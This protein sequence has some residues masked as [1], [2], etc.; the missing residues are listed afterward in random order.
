MRAMVT[1]AAGF[2]GSHICE[3]LI[4]EGN[5]VVGVDNLSTGDMANISQFVKEMDFNEVNVCHRGVMRRLMSGVDVV[6]HQAALGSVPRS[7]IDPQ[8]SHQNNVEGT[9]SVLDAARDANVQRVV[10]ASSSSVY[11]GGALCSEDDTL[12]PKSPYAA[13]KV[14]GEAFCQ[15]YLEAYGLETVCLRYFNVYGPRQNPEGPYAAVIPKFI[16]AQR[17]KQPMTIFGDG[18]AKRDFTYIDD[19]VWANMLAA[20]PGRGVAGMSFNVCTGRATSIEHLAEDLNALRR[21]G[22][23]GVAH[24]AARPG[25]VEESK[26]DPSKAARLLG[27]RSSTELQVG[28]AR[29][30]SWFAINQSLHQR[31]QAQP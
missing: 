31:D 25:D 5:E 3:R 8:A 20:Q 4:R 14:A 17:N 1:G 24:L 6:F 22:D 19:V 29:T 11:G 10:F 9:L 16:M 13:T 21:S 12:K 7:V 30:A 2:I 26:G 27:F 23:G 15:A 28:L 18:K